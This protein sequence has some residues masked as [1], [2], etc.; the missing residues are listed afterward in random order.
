M[1]DII[2]AILFRQRTGNRWIWLRVFFTYKQ[3]ADR[4]KM[5]ATRESKTRPARCEPNQIN[6][7]KGP[8]RNKK[9]LRVVVPQLRRPEWWRRK[10]VVVHNVVDFCEF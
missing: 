2:F 9:N 1:L 3:H 6:K 5:W 4:L 10:A 7:G 8:K